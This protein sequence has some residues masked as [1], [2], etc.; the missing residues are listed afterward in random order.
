MK[1]DESRSK[2][3]EIVFKN[4]ISSFKI[5]KQCYI[6]VC[7]GFGKTR[8]CTDFLFPFLKSKKENIKIL[9]LTGSTQVLKRWEQEQDNNFDVKTWQSL[10]KE[11]TNIVYDFL[12]VDEADRLVTTKKYKRALKVIK[13]AYTLYMSG[14]W[15]SNHVAEMRNMGAKLADKITRRE[16]LR[17]KWISSWTEYNVAIPL[18][19]E[20]SKWLKKT[21]VDEY[22][23]ILNYL[24]PNIEDP[25]DEF[26]M[27]YADFSV[28]R[29]IKYK[30][31]IGY[32]SLEGYLIKCNEFN[33]KHQYEYYKHN[34]KHY[35]SGKKKGK[36]VTIYEYTNAKNLAQKRGVNIF[37]VLRKAAEASKLNRK[38]LEFIYNHKAKAYVV[39]EILNNIEYNKAVVF[40]SESKLVDI[41][42]DLNKDAIP[43]HSN[44]KSEELSTPK[45]LKKYFD[46]FVSNEGRN[47]LV[48]IRKIEAGTDV[49][50]IDLSINASY[51]STWTS[52]I[53]KDG[54]S[55][56][57]EGDKNTIII[58]LYLDYH[59]SF[60]G[61]NGDKV[62]VEKRW[63]DKSQ[64]KSNCEIIE[65]KYQDIWKYLKKK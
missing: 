12:V 25:E 54:R 10:Y 8:I 49:K 17:N 24:D 14:S 63:L 13:R 11:K 27:N 38:R 61:Y 44:L 36:P 16:A 37:T 33:K 57:K 28:L 50:N 22:T 9:I 21:F 7:P 48:N 19:Y 6:D 62:T 26:N 51:N 30:Q 53:Q 42:C 58:N 20:E 55:L 52:K 39:N 45:L 31:I 40:C 34:I 65:I 64:K 43:Y 4:I 56:R 41:I 47:A 5:S 2:R 35:K 1:L 23:S 29:Q 3:Q 59:Q 32:R 46:E 60:K 18:S 15:G